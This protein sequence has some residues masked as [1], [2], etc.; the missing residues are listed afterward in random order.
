M[1]KKNS[2]FKEVSL[3]SKNPRGVELYIAMGD[4]TVQLKSCAA[5]NDYLFHSPTRGDL[6][7]APSPSMVKVPVKRAGLCVWRTKG[8]DWPLVLL[9]SK[10]CTLKDQHG[11]LGLLQ[12][13]FHKSE[14]PRWS[15]L[16]CRYCAPSSARERHAELNLEFL[17]HTLQT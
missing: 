13:E 9:A 10:C 1:R 14:L 2:G 6:C 4:G 7:Q 5:L 3:L 8:W 17:Q 16:P 12:T 11:L 15:H